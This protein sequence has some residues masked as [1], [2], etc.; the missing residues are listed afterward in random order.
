MPGREGI[1]IHKGNTTRDTRGCILPGMGF[2]EVDGLDAVTQSAKAME[3][4]R[5]MF[6]YPGEFDL[7]I[8]EAY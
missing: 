5:G 8:K 1:L 7:L 3:R 2:G 6:S 4:L